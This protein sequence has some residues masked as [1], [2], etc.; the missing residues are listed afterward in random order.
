M[1]YPVLTSEIVKQVDK[2]NYTQQ[3]D[4]LGYVSKISSDPRNESYR[5]KAI[6]EIRKAL[7]VS[8]DF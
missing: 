2:L 4:V 3:S 5:K 8:G 6:K 1:I 7:T